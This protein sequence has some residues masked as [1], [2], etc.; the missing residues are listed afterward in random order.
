MFT[1]VS[2]SGLPLETP[3]LAKGYI[4][5]LGCIL[6][7]SMSINTK[8]I[9]SK[10]NEALVENLLRKLH[11]RYT[12]PQPFKKGGEFSNHEDEHRLEQLEIPGEE[13]DQ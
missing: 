7:E 6:W 12:F 1:V 2:P 5:Q 13:E 3:E 4:M 11:Q 8:D 10:A 9:R